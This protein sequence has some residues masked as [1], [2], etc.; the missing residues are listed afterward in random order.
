MLYLP[1]TKRYYGDTYCLR[2]IWIYLYS[3]VFSL[4]LIFGVL[5]IFTAKFNLALGMGRI[6]RGFSNIGVSLGCLYYF[7]TTVCSQMTSGGDLCHIGISKLTC[8]ANR[9][10]GSC[11][12]QFLPRG[13][14]E[15]TMILHFGRSAK[16]TTV[17]CFSIRGGDARVSAVSR[18]WGV[19]DFLEKSLIYWVITGLGCVFT[20]V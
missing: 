1:C 5:I 7:R 9:W 16:Y 12:I 11:V 20:L 6:S 8:E 13:R 14:S 4:E 2:S 3:Y 15:Q 18:T 17:L 10:T 19:L